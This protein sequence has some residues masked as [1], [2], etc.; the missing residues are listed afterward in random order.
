MPT[1][2]SERVKPAVPRTDQQR[3]ATCAV[4][5]ASPSGTSMRTARC[6]L[7]VSACTTRSAAS[8]IVGGCSTATRRHAV[9][10]QV[11][12]P[13][14]QPGPMSTSYG[15]SAATL[16]DVRAHHGHLASDDGDDLVG[17][18]R[19]SVATVIVATSA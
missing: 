2:A 4:L 7:A 1:T 8:T 12:D 13:I 15:S 3:A 6:P 14:V 18:L 10:E 9:A 11:R 5:A 17:R 19:P 16:D